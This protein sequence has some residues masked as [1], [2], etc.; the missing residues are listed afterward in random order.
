M[1]NF[2][3][4]QLVLIKKCISA[5]C[6]LLCVLFMLFN[7]FTYTSSTEMLSGTEYLTWTDGFSMFSFL[8]NGKQRVLETNITLIRE[9][10][11]FSYVVVWISFILQILSLG[12]LIYGIFSKKSLFSKIGSVSL[13]ASY[14][15][16]I[17]I[18]FD[19][20]SLGRTIRYLSVFNL[21]YFLELVLCGMSV[22]SSFTIKTK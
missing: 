3:N 15:I 11:S 12:I 16:L 1:K 4:K 19:T 22:F 21:F 10:F 2:T 8:F 6:A 5:G 7:L 18:S 14:A 20:Y 17:L 9:I 13:L